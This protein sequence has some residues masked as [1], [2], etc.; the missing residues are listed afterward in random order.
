M[1]EV[2]KYLWDFLEM[3]GSSLQSLDLSSCTAPSE[4]FGRAAIA[5]PHLIELKILN[6]R[7]VGADLLQV[8]RELKNLKSLSFSFLSPERPNCA[9]DSENGRLFS[10]IKNL[11]VEASPEDYANLRFIICVLNRCQAI[12]R[13]HIS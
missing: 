10:S 6:T 1:N 5:C 4:E 8:L 9:V 11:Y 3:T 2:T 12:E 13:T 7:L